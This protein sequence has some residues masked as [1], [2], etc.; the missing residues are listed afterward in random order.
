MA[1]RDGNKAKRG[2]KRKRGKT[3]DVAEEKQVEKIRLVRDKSGLYRIRKSSQSLSLLTPTILSASPHTR[4]ALSPKE[5]ED[6]TF[7]SSQR[8]D[9]EVVGSPL[10]NHSSPDSSCGEPK[11]V[12]PVSP[13]HNAPSR[14]GSDKSPN[15]L[16]MS[17]EQCPVCSVVLHKN[18]TVLAR[19][20]RESHNHCEY[21]QFRDELRSMGVGI[22]DMCHTS[23]PLKKD[24]SLPL[25]KCEAP[26]REE[27]QEQEDEEEPEKDQGAEPWP[28]GVPLPPPGMPHPFHYQQVPVLCAVPPP[29]RDDWAEVLS[30]A[31]SRL[32]AA[33]TDQNDQ[34]IGKALNAWLSI[35]DSLVKPKRGG[36]NTSAKTVG[37]A[38]A[39]AISA[40]ETGTYREKVLTG[41]HTYVPSEEEAKRI[42]RAD[43]LVRRGWRSRAAKTL[44]SDESMTVLKGEKLLAF[45][46]KFPLPRAHIEELEKPLPDDDLFV[47]DEATFVVTLKATFN[48]AAGGQSGLMGE[49]VR[50]V[51]H[52]PRVQT[53]L[54]QMFTLLINGN[55]PQW[56]HPYVCTQRLFALGD[57]ARPVCVGEWMAR[58]AS[59]LCESR[60]EAKKSSDYFLHSG[61]GFKVLQFGTDVRGGMEAMVLIANALVHEVGKGRVLIKKDGVNA[62]NSSDRLE[63]VRVT[64]RVFPTTSR[65]GRWYYGTPSLLRMSSGEWMWGGGRG[66][67]RGIRTLEGHTIPYCRRL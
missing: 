10:P 17:H 36:W 28:K 50:D 52:Y 42:A 62:Y 14:E 51:L 4:Q 20:L 35:T 27:T 67:F 61:K 6:A 30:R 57:K 16:D 43:S 33:I 12:T 44:R 56:T 31:A 2:G 58:T 5:K 37:R 53:A 49:H 18:K 65:W 24:G 54:L 55:F 46:A 9:V 41:A 3:G 29:N 23:R 26:D 1:E 22:C 40:E 21:E 11:G 25:H 48:G 47:M 38:L 64:S 19:H 60:V 32:S 15:D 7:P 34:A 63:G 8:D 13:L 45:R 59:R 39:K 66:S